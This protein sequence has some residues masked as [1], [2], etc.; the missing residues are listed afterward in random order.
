ME[1]ASR[2][3]RGSMPDI[4]ARLKDTEINMEDVEDIVVTLTQGTHQI[5]K[6]GEDVTPDRN[7]VIC[8]LTERESLALREKQAMRVM[9]NWTYLDSDGVKRRGSAVG[10][11]IYITEQDL[12]EEIT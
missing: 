9:L 10:R 7:S 8:H 2:Y 3:V 11:E 1:T 12:E 5:K 6:R 4:R